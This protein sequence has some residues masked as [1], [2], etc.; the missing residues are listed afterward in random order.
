MTDT[1]RFSGVHPIL[2]AFFDET[3][4]IDAAAMRK[5]TDAC[6]ATGAHGIVVLGNVTEAAKLDSAERRHLMEVVGE[7]VASRVPYGVTIGEPSIAG[8]IDFARAA[9]AAGADWVIL[10]P[11]Q[12]K[13]MPESQIVRFLGKVAEGCDLPVAVQ[14]NPINMDVW[15]T[16]D[17]LVALHRNHPNITMLKGEGPAIGVHAL[18]QATGGSLS[19]FAGQGGIEFITN[20]R[21][22]CVGLV[23]A[24]D[25]LAQQL[26]IHE[27]WQRGTDDA[28]AEALALHRGT[29]P[30]ITLM[31]RN[32][33][34]HQLP[35]GK[36]WVARHLGLEVHNRIPSA[37]ASEFG[38]AECDLLVPGLDPFSGAAR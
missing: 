4:A 25:C 35:L 12:V 26:R 7:A 19:V 32:L 18:I 6:I 37:P 29:L 1:P 21:S 3:G 8:Q 31:T 34:T 36:R 20:L 30:L 17:S 2:Y 10:Q 13:G 15:L 22:G 38:L 9:A 5:Q 28:Q 23:P 16:N 24:P 11:P 33:N 14:N 27:L